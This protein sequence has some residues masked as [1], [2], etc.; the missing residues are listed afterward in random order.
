[1]S[2]R[3]KEAEKYWDQLAWLYQTE[4]RISLSRFHLGPLLP[5]ADHF[6]LL[7]EN[8]DGMRALE[9]GCGAGQNSIVL[10]SRGML[11]TALDCSMQMLEHGRQLAERAN[12]SVHFLQGDM[13]QIETQ[14]VPERFDFIHSTYAL[15][16][17]SNPA[18]VICACAKL[19][20]PGGSFLL[21]TAHPAYA[22]AWIELDDDEDGL[23][24]PDYFHP[25]SDCREDEN[26]VGIRAEYALLSD[27]FRWI[28]DAGLSAD[29]FLE[30]RP[31]DIE[32]LNHEEIEATLAYW[33]PDWLALYPQLKRVPVVAVFSCTKPMPSDGPGS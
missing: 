31:I 3:S 18:H 22:G 20:K 15:P 8:P 30:P 7:P 5:D 24:I 16:F 9:I 6:G 27:L 12:V 23:F 26:G 19:L 11:A 2:I 32:A 17:C 33:S 25:D 10:A 4:N 28:R 13:E 29:R 14:V 21:T 1:M